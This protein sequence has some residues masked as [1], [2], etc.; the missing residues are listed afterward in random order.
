[1]IGRVQLTCHR[2][3][4]LFTYIRTT[5]ANG[6]FTR[7]QYLSLDLLSVATMKA[8]ILCS[9]ALFSW[10]AFAFPAN[11]LNNFPADLSD[12]ALAEVTELAAKIT[13]EVETKRQ[14]GASILP[15]GFDADAQR[16]STTG[17]HR[18]VCQNPE[19]DSCLMQQSLKLPS[20]DRARSE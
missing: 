12:E 14:L 19:V 8:S 7:H 17:D 3:L 20:T 9:V 5:T 16:I 4:T 13:R 15:P 1:M 11:L 18:Y 10:A 6:Y 2:D